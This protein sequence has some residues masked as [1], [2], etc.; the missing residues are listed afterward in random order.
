MVTDPAALYKMADEAGRKAVEALQ[1]SPMIV[2]QRENPF[3]DTSALKKAWYVSDGVCGFAWV[4][5]KPATSKFAK[6]LVSIGI[7]RKDSYYGG[8]CVWVRDYGQSMQKKEA[9]AH[10]FADVLRING[11]EKVY[12]SSRMD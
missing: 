11:I 7:A 3:D 2:T 6:Y 4:N 5:I 9:Y 10:A 12:A 1:V 8:I